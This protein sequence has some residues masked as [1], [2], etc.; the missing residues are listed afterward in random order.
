MGGVRVLDMQAINEGTDKFEMVYARP[1]EFEGFTDDL[2]NTN[3]LGYYKILMEVLP[4][5]EDEVRENS[6]DKKMSYMKTIRKEEKV[7]SL[8]E[9]IM[10]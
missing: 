9:M 8:E 2:E 1:W 7:K 3:N 10:H 6:E 4:V 5:P